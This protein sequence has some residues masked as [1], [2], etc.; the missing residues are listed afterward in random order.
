MGTFKQLI[1]NNQPMTEKEYT[2]AKIAMIIGG[3]AI[4]CGGSFVGVSY[5]AALL[6]YLGASEVLSNFVLSLATIPGFF[7]I[8]VPYII[9]N[10]KYKKPFVIVCM[11]FEYFLLGL[12]FLLPAITGRTTI[13]VVLAAC[14]FAVHSIITNVKNPANQEWL[15]NC[16]N[17]QGGGASSF[18]GLKDG[19][20]NALLILTYLVL[21][22]MTKHFVGEKEGTG[23]VIM[24]SIAIVMWFISLVSH[25]VIKEP[26]NPPKQKVKVNFFKMLKNLVTYKPYMPYLK[27]YM[28]YTIGTYLINSL[29]PVMNVQVFGLKLEI[30][31]YFTVI[32]LIFRVVLAVVFGKLADKIG[33]KP[34][35]SIGMFAF[36]VNSLLYLFMT[37]SNAYLFKFISIPFCAIANT[38]ICAPSFVFMFECLPKQNT[39]GFI[40]CHGVISYIAATIVAFSSAFFVDAFHGTQLNIFARTFT[41]MNLVFLVSAIAFIIGAINLLIK[42]K[43]E[44]SI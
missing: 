9:T 32:D 1:F 27:F 23:Y 4:S 25:F 29:M 24:G 3:A 5:F 15:L 22:V 41:E 6:K 43:K 16:A 30:L 40:A 31:S 18:F 14:F 28:Y 39:S 12:A 7:L 13:S 10:L 11:L 35:I 8:F 20:A 42:H 36:A 19:I 17:G 38:A 44:K 37:T 34:V 21:G 2:T 26:Y 33:T